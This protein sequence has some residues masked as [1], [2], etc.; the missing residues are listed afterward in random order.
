MTHKV[1]VVT[2]LGPGDGGKGGVVHKVAT[3]MRARTIIK[4]G[5]AQGSH[6]VVT[7]R[8]EKF[9]FSQWGC[10]TF[11]GIP[12]HLSEE[13]ILHPIGLLNEAK[14]LRYQHGI[15]DPFSL[16]TVDERALCA[17]PFHGIASRLYELARRENPR[18]TIGTG[19]GEAYRNYRQDP[20]L[21]I[22]ARD[23]KRPDLKDR[24]AAI[25]EAIQAE[26]IDVIEGDFLP[27]D[28][29]V[30]KEETLWL[31]D[32]NYLNHVADAFAEVANCLRVVGHEYL[33]ETILAREG[34]AVVEAS[35]GVL[36]DRLMGLHPHT[37]AIRTLPQFTHDMLRRAGFGGQIV[38]IGV[39]RAYSIR[40]GAGPMPTAEPEMAERLLPGSHK[41]EN[42]YQGKVRVGPLDL[43]LMRYAL[44]VCGGTQAF[45]G[46]AITWFDQI[47]SNGAWHICDRYSGADNPDLF[48]SAGKIKLHHGSGLE[49][50]KHQ[51]ALGQKL[52]ECTPEVMS[53]PV[54]SGASRDQLYAFCAST[55]E[56][57]V[58]V[59]VRM[60]S[61]GPPEQDKLCK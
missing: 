12:T 49:Q 2:D 15:Y 25:R 48:S 46:L 37:S 39:H 47:T 17:T 38:D 6:G 28:Q 34:V 59:P 54:P 61:F 58:G 41:D 20:A 22:T 45:D 19:V 53:L 21:S 10:G 55:V 35:H 8:G 43:V 50:L 1:Y 7:S 52:L 40:H 4:R 26:L 29:R 51:Q 16:L 44:E 30:A 31:F 57:A 5:G 60:V 3:M 14:T 24:L 13:M 36:T 18:G 27:D 42:R 11:E 33:G 9:A 23:L 56:E 32:D